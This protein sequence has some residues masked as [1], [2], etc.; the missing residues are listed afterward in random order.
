[1]KIYPMIGSVRFAAQKKINLPLKNKGG[2]SI[3]HQ[4]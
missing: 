3:I 4:Y 2:T 1:L